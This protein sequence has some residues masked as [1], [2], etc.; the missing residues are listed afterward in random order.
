MAKILDR[1]ATVTEHQAL[2]A[3]VGWEDHFDAASLPQAL[4]GSLF[5]VVAVVDADVVGMARLVGD[6]VSY[7]YVQDVIVHPDH[8]DDGLGTAL[9]KRLIDWVASVAPAPAFVGLFASDEAIGVYESLS[10][11][12]GDSTGMSLTVVP[13]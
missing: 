5:G 12:T 8:A 6:G 4:S 7:F 1:V 11:S 2:A 9:V 13:R 10:F 3:A